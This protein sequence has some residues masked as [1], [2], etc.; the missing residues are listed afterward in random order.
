MPSAFCILHFALCI[1]HL[2]EYCIAT[3]SRRSLVLPPPRAAF[4]TPRR[5]QVAHKCNS[6]IQLGAVRTKSHQGAAIVKL[7]NDT[8]EWQGHALSSCS[9]GTNRP[10]EPIASQSRAPRHPA[11]RS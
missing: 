5:Q 8:Q 10:G 1:L 2:A 11:A 3:N 4:S 9:L 6:T 7:K